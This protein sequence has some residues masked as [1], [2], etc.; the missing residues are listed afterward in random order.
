[1]CILVMF[2]LAAVTYVYENIMLAAGIQFFR[3]KGQL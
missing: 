3:I 2:F 1:M